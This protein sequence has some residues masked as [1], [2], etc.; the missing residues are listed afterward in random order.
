MFLIAF[1]SFNLS[2]QTY[3]Y[4]GTI[5]VSVGIGSCERV[6]SV[7]YDIKMKHNDNGQCGEWIFSVAFPQLSN[8]NTFSPNPKWV[9][10]RNVV[11]NEIEYGSEIAFYVSSQQ[12]NIELS[13]IIEDMCNVQHRF[14]FG[15]FY[16][17]QSETCFTG[18]SIMNYCDLTDGCI[19]TPNQDYYERLSWFYLYDPVNDECLLFN[20]NNNPG[21][22]FRFP[23][24]IYSDGNCDLIPPDADLYDFIDDL[25]LYLLTYGHSGSASI[26]HYSIPLECKIKIKLLNSDLV[27]HKFYEDCYKLFYKVDQFGL[28][29]DSWILLNGFLLQR[30]E[31]EEFAGIDLSGLWTCPGPGGNKNYDY[32]DND[33]AD[34]NDL[35]NFFDFVIYPNIT[36]DEISIEW[37]IIQDSNY[38]L[39]IFNTV[40]DLIVEKNIENK[41]N[42]M[43]LNI[44]NYK[45]G[46]YYISLYSYLTG[47]N[48]VHKFIK[49]K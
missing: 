4:N 22:I 32:E 18:R 3:T 43:K 39:T 28:C 38:K 20:S 9:G 29:Y 36:N 47:K 12:A 27:F 1:S 15:P 14:S 11:T 19:T 8:G 41:Y 45:A 7:N 31:V 24:K 5:P 21:N 34:K 26:K 33:Y 25:N 13:F 16:I 30:A 2:A 10:W 46:V 23:Y 44:K 40:G 6:T 35:I 37:S 42:E 48:I 17:S 49:I